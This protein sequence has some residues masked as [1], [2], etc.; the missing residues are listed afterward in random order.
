[1]KNHHNNWKNNINKYHIDFFFIFVNQ[2]LKLKKWRALK[3][4]LVYWL[5]ACYLQAVTCQIPEK[6]PL[7]GEVAG[8]LSAPDCDFRKRQRSCYRCCRGCCRRNNGRSPYRKE[9]GQSGRTSQTGRRCTSRA[10]YR[11]QWITSCK[12]DI[13]LGNPFL[14]KQFKPQ[15]IG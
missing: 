8:P 11:Q 2:F 13:R 5:P 3:L 4:C 14:D 6:E 7:S 15:F 10:S 1:M 12:S 9:N